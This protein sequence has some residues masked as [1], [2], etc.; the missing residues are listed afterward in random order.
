MAALEAMAS[1]VPVIATASGGLPEVVVNGETGYLLPVGDVAGMAE[2]GIEILRD[3]DLRKRMGKLSRELAVDRFDE[4]KIVPVYRE[5]Y[6]RVI[7]GKS[8]SHRVQPPWLDQDAP[9]FV[10]G[11]LATIGNEETV[12]LLGP[13]VSVRVAT[14]GR[15]GHRGIVR[16]AVVNA[17]PVERWPLRPPLLGMVA[18]SV[19]LGGAG[20]RARARAL[21]TMQP[22][23]GRSGHRSKG[24]ARYPT[25]TVPP[26]SRLSGR[27]CRR[28][29]NSARRSS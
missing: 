23:G 9:A 2:R 7:E 26:A 6:D 15:P 27:R 16:L 1:E 22:V 21:P 25:P 17:M 20:T 14:R 5:M 11:S 12:A 13:L 4:Q 29:P 28:S 19:T 24:I 10:L 18:S 3:D 8:A